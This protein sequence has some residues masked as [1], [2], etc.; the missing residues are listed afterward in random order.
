MSNIDYLYANDPF[1]GII[2]EHVEE[3]SFLWQRRAKAVKQPNHTIASVQ[4]LEQ[5]ITKHIAGL[6][7]DSEATWDFCEQAL[8]NF[9]DDGET[10]TA[11]VLA[12][13]S[14]ETYKIQRVMEHAFTSENKTA[15][16]GFISA[17]GWLPKHLTHP[18]IEQCL[19][20]EN[21]QEKYLAIAACSVRRENPGKELLRILQNENY[22]DHPALYARALRLTGELKFHNISPLVNNIAQQTTTQNQAE[23]NDIAFWSHWSAILLG[24][25]NAYNGIK[26]Y[27]FENS[28]YQGQAIETIFRCLDLEQ[29]RRW[30]HDLANTPHQT[31][32][33]I[34][35]CMALGDPAAIPSLIN[36]MKAPLLARI[37]GEAFTHITGVNIESAGF[38]RNAPP[39][40]WR[41]IEESI[42][43]DGDDENDGDEELE[44]KI[45]AQC[46]FEGS[47]VEEDSF[48]P[49]PDPQK[50]R[51]YWQKHHHSVTQK[52]RYFL[53]QPIH[54]AHSQQVLAQGTQRHRRA[55]ALELALSKDRHMLVNTSA[56]MLSGA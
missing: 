9:G 33:V 31:R 49:W 38:C 15:C 14:Q 2:E 8:D 25:K 23:S 10:F 19:F 6:R 22:R 47:S 35:S 53:G 21:P 46:Y 54:P 37:A 1:A 56:K 52:Q 11:A 28:I 12:L 41:T 24:N 4:K 51:N 16:N 36:Y 39:E 5:R 29:S 13:E 42:E 55:A 3:L 45:Q 50:I 18:L 30:I 32:Q 26:P 27:V 43:E 48:L 17:L 20:S 40:E 44:H 34:Q 7:L